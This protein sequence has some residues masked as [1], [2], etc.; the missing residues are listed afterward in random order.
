MSTYIDD[1]TKEFNIDGNNIIAVVTE[2]TVDSEE[3]DNGFEVLVV[4]FECETTSLDWL[5]SESEEHILEGCIVSHIKE[6]YSELEE[7]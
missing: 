7:I 1:F 2:I 3:D 5:M 6:L 4:M